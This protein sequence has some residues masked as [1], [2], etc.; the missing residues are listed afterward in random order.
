MDVYM[1]PWRDFA[2]AGGRGMMASHNSIND[3]P[4]HGNQA[5]LTD[6]M[7]NLFGFNGGLIASDDSDIAAIADF[8]VA[9]NVTMAAA[10]SVEAGMDQDLHGVAFPTLNQSVSS[11]D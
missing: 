11:A 8:G 2:A 5:M 4:A 7:R 3:V 10:I 1:R 9:A 6:V